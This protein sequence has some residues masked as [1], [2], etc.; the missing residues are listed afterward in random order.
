MA[1][2]FA[3]GD[4]GN[5]VMIRLSPGTN[6]LEGIRRVCEELDIVCGAVVS[7]IGSLRRASFMV[8]VPLVSKVGAGYSDL[9]NVEGPLELLSGQGSIGEGKDKGIFVHL[10]AVVSDKEGKLSG[11]HLV[12]G[13]NPVLIT[14]EIMIV[15]V[16]GMTMHRSYDSEVDMDLLMPS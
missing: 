10:H 1:I 15:Q 3:R 5:V 14:S 9:L 8:A 7:C 16:L 4:S 2:Q 13:A 6:I 12:R 11:G